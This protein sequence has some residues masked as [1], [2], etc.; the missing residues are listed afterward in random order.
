MID[1]ETLLIIEIEII[2]TI[3]IEIIQMIETKGIKTLVH[4]IILTTDQSIKDQIVTTINIDHAITHKTE[5]QTMTINQET[6]LNHYIGITHVNQI[7]KTN[8]EGTSQ[9]I[10]DK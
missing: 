4:V 10:K 9:N 5:I 1:Q 6:T 2:P 8:I 7:P 3:G